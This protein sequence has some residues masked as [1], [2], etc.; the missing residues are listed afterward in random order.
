MGSFRSIS[1]RRIAATAAAVALAL[2]APATAAS[3]GALENSGQ[4]YYECITTAGWSY[5]LQ[6]GDPLSSCKGSY[7]KTYIAGRLVSTIPL[8]GYGTPANPMSVNIDCV[9]AILGTGASVITLEGR[10]SFVALGAS[11]YG[12]K[13]CVA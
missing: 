8:T 5:M 13:T 12:L 3:A 10:W 2:V 6:P 9:I 4:Y 7:L 11:I 1:R